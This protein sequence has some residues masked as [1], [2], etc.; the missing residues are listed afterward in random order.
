M[1]DKILLNERTRV[2]E[3]LSYQILDTPPEQAYDDIVQL[4][5]EICE[6]PIAMVTLID[7]DRQW[8]KSKIGIEA[9]ELPRV[10]AF[11]SHAILE[12]NEIFLVENA[13]TDERFVNN[14]LVTGEPHIKFYAGAPLVTENGEALGTLCVIDEKPRELTEKQ[15]ISLR[16]LARQIVAQLELR[17]TIRQMREV[18]ARQKEIETA[19][20]ESEERFKAFMNNNPAVAY[21]KDEA[22]R[23][24]Y[25]NKVFERLFN[26]GEK[27]LLGK[28]DYDYLPA[29]A[30]TAVQKN[31]AL[32]LSE[33][34]P[35]EV[36]ESVPTPDGSA[37][38][39]MSLK[40]PFIDTGGKKFVG[41]VSIDITARKIAEEQLNES[42]KRY[43]HLFEFSPGF[44]NTHDLDGVITSVNEAAAHALGYLPAEL[45]G[46]NLAEFV[47]PESNPFFADYLEQMSKT[48]LKEGVMY[49][50]TKTGEQRIWQYRN[51]LFERKDAPPVVIGYA[52]DI[53]ELKLFQKELHELTLTDELTNLYNRRGFF[54]LAGQALRYARRTNKECIVIYADLDN[55]KMVNDKFGH[56]TGSQMIVDASTVFRSFFRDSDIAARLGGDE[57]VILVQDSS[58][59]GTEIIQ[60]RLQELIEEFNE[61]N[62]RP[63]SMSISFGIAHFDPKTKATIEELVSEADR[64]MYIQKQ[65]KKT[66]S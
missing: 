26:L 19:L 7:N 39:W 12:P 33:W 8:F 34:K 3:L 20:R 24:V 48:S 40:F 29:E 27:E 56:D 6:T 43:R 50:L 46:K 2:E 42:E 5:S 15:K 53:T 35:M 28:T 30:A 44:I 9:D 45:I 38:Y 62:P 4:A 63:Y 55:L 16:V 52:Q 49:V 14:P 66:Q 32:V 13:Q 58:E 59:A 36:T 11:C 10:T 60:E 64:L 65:S 25:V 21:M 54:T 57:F 37:S 23:L 22:G 47:T 17:R 31:D 61:N 51:R 18:E 1:Q 41:G